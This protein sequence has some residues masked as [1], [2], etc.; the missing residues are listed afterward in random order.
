MSVLEAW[1][2]E[3]PVLMTEACNLPEGFAEGAALRIAPAP[4]QLASDLEKALV[5]APERLAAIGSAGRR[6]V[7]ARFGWEG[8]ARGHTEVYSWMM[9]GAPRDDA[10]AVV[11]FI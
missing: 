4:A 2:Y 9:R 1:A 5:F 3:L 7:S 6:L 8:I 11:T 10:P